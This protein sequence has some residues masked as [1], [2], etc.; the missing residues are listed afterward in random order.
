MPKPLDQ[1]GSVDT[2]RILEID[3]STL[4]R[5]VA[6][7]QITPLMQLPGRTG[8]YLFDR[9]DVERLAAERRSA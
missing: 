6:S 7:R 4:S 3:R 1:I 5:W 8:A 2:C 9:A